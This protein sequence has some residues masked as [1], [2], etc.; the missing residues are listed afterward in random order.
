MIDFKEKIEQRPIKVTVAEQIETA[1]ASYSG[2]AVILIPDGDQGMKVFYR[3]GHSG[4]GGAWW[5][6]KYNESAAGVN[7]AHFLTGVEHAVLIAREDVDD[8]IAR[9]KIFMDP[10]EV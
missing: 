9:R 2:A 10:Q 7:L 3:S 1:L 8:L 4:G 5:E 6:T